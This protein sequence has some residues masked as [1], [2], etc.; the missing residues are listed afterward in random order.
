MYKTIMVF[1]GLIA[2]CSEERVI[3]AVVTSED[4][5]DGA[6]F[7]VTTED[8][9]ERFK[10]DASRFGYIAPGTEVLFDRDPHDPSATLLESTPSPKE[11]VRFLASYGEQIFGPDEGVVLYSIEAIEW[12]SPIESEQTVGWTM[13][14]FRLETPPKPLDTPDLNH[15]QWWQ[16]EVPSSLLELVWEGDALRPAAEIWIDGWW[17]RAGSWGLIFR[18]VSVQRE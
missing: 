13:F 17:G 12:D 4:V 2:G 9:H 3:S 14:E 7:K 10:L 1:V 18:Q 5:W 8:P 15:F 6:W 11:T 16:V